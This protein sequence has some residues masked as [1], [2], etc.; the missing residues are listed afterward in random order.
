VSKQKSPIQHRAIPWGKFFR[1]TISFLKKPDPVLFGFIGLFFLLSLPG[2]NDFPDMK[3]LD[4]TALWIWGTQIL[5]FFAVSYFVFV[6]FVLWIEKKSS[7]AAPVQLKKI[8]VDA[9]ELMVPLTILSIRGALLFT[10]GLVLLVIPGLYW[11]FKYE[12]AS[13]CLI[14]E[15]WQDECPPVARAEQIIANYGLGLFLLPTIMV[16]EWASSWVLEGAFRLQ[17][18]P[19]T[20][21]IKMGITSIETAITVFTNLFMTLAVSFLIKDAQS[22]SKSR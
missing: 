21:P 14:L 18:T 10:V 1:E 5:V 2:L 17:G 9:G 20:F 13:F 7:S 16:G 22:S 12:L 19:I 4:P 15:G 8:V 11:S 3:N 6:V